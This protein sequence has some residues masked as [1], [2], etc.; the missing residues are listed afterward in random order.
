MP[1]KNRWAVVVWTDGAAKVL[2]RTHSKARAEAFIA[3]IDR[4]HVRVGLV[5]AK[6]GAALKE[7][8]S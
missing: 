1:K 6:F 4:K 5:K 3:T 8:S 7:Y 2:L